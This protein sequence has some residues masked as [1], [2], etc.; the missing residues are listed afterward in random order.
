[1]R[2][3]GHG[4]DPQVDALCSVQPRLELWNHLIPSIARARS[5]PT[6]PS[7]RPAGMRA[8]RAA[9]SM[10]VLSRASIHAVIATLD[11]SAAGFGF[12]PDRLL[13][14]MLRAYPDAGGGA[15]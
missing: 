8:D 12:R 5:T 6:F 1:M 3:G 14:A 11:R 10:S 2:H 7:H 15:M 9:A 4:A 13:P